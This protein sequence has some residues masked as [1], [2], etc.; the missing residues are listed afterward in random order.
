M[1]E[2][3]ARKT[4]GFPGN[5]FS[6]S[7]TRI[8]EAKR[9]QNGSKTEAPKKIGFHL[10]VSRKIGSER[11]SGNFFGAPSVSH[12]GEPCL[13]QIER[14]CELYPHNGS[15]LFLGALGIFLRTFFFELLHD[16]LGCRFQINL[17]EKLNFTRITEAK[18]K[19]NGSRTEAF[20]KNSPSFSGSE[21]LRLLTLP[22]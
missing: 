16:I 11:S 1:K 9:K 2:K 7:F 20:Q 3:C 15:K 8:T 21:F 4:S 18:R 6:Y 17:G 19:R 14:K 12:F 10:R 5:L 22:A 13:N